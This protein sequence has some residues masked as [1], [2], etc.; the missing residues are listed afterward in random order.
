MAAEGVENQFIML[1]L[2]NFQTGNEI[3]IFV[4]NQFMTSV[5]PSSNN[6]KLLPEIHNITETK[7]NCFTLSLT[8]ILNSSC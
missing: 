8:G 7:H 3:Q 2:Y 5:Y 4:L 6:V 1:K